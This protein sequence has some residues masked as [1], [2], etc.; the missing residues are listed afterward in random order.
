MHLVR[1]ILPLCDNEGRAFARAEFDRVRDE[2]TEHFGGVTAF[3][4][5]PAEG[6]WKEDEGS[7]TRDEVVVYEVMAERLERAW[8][9]DYRGS[10]ARRFRQDEYVAREAAPYRIEYAGDWPSAG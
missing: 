10:L 7:V 3:R 9:A 5:S 4:R 2:L 6:A 8:W 1:L